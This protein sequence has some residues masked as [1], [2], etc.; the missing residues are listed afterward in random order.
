[1]KRN[2]EYDE[3]VVEQTRLQ[4]HLTEKETE[5]INREGIFSRLLLTFNIIVT[6]HIEGGRR[7]KCS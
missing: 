6:D 5:M 7:R 2:R 3:L 4:A 1:M